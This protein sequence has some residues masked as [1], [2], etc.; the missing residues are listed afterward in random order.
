MSK[1]F[2]DYPKV[3]QRIILMALEHDLNGKIIDEI[4][5][6][7]GKE[8]G[9]EISF[10]INGVV[11]DFE[12]V[13]ERMD[14]AFS[15]MVERR[16]AKITGYKNHIKHVENTITELQNAVFKAQRDLGNFLEDENEDEF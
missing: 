5:E 9:L 11:L 8:G 12:N 13:A 10:I 14:E 4:Y 3:A 16:A 15:Y 2:D 1:S 6:K 7:E